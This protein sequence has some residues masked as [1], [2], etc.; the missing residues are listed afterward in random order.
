MSEV[1]VDVII[2]ETRSDPR[3]PVAKKSRKIMPQQ[4]RRTTASRTKQ[5]VANF[6]MKINYW[7]IAKVNE[8]KVKLKGL[9]T[10]NQNPKVDARKFS[11]MWGIGI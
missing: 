11:Q 9:D 4:L 5:M 10:V 1:D 7:H 6:T 8:T 3:D 2:L